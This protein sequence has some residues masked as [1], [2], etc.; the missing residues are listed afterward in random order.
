[1]EL[2]GIAVVSELDVLADCGHSSLLRAN[3]R[4]QAHHLIYVR[5]PHRSCSE[6]TI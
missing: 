6:D 1:M 4:I 2:T 5:R 3:I